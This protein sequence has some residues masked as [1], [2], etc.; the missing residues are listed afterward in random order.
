MNVWYI[1]EGVNVTIDLYWT[2]HIKI[3]CKKLRGRIF[4][5]RYDIFS[6]SSRVKLHLNKVFKIQKAAVRGTIKN[7]QDDS[8]KLFFKLLKIITLY[9]VIIIIYIYKKN[10]N[11]TTTTDNHFYET[12]KVDCLGHIT[13]IFN[14]IMH[15]ILLL[16]FCQ[17]MI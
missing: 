15:F 7:N 6:M 13:L 14:F 11:Y 2:E 3:L 4:T 16:S 1:C 10:I 12:W 9:S 5:I 8:Y 17:L